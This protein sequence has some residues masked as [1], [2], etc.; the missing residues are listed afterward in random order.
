[1]LK[2]SQQT[3]ATL[4]GRFQRD[5]Q[6]VKKKQIATALGRFQRDKFT[7]H[8]NCLQLSCWKHLSKR[9]QQL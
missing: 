8:Y 7:L 5:K 3:R 9:E 2:A 6:Y 1:M 4:S